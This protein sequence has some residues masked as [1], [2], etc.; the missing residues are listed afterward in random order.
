M[1]KSKHGVGEIKL[2]ESAKFVG[3][4][5]DLSRRLKKLATSAVKEK[6]YGH[7]QPAGNREN[8]QSVLPTVSQTTVDDGP[9]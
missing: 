7:K 1:E 9:K 3:L 6:H 8:K 5:E 2:S 4:L